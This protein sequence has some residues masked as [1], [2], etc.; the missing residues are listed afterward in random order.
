MVIWDKK[1]YVASGLERVNG[2]II[3]LASTATKKIVLT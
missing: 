1:F 3:D 2:R